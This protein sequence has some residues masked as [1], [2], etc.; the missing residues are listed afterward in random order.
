MILQT[1]RTQFLRTVEL[2]VCLCAI[3]FLSTSVFAQQQPAGEK[4]DVV[5][6]LFYRGDSDQSLRGKEFLEQLQARRPGLEIKAYDVLEDRAQLKRLWQLSKKFGHESGRAPTFYLCNNLLVGFRGAQTTG[7]QIEELLSIRAYIRPGCKHCKAGKAFLDKMMLRR[8]AIKVYYYD[9]IG[10]LNA[11]QEVQNLAAR[12]QVQIPSFPCIQVAGRLVV[13]YQTDETTGKKIEG[14]FVDRSLSTPA[15]Q[16]TI[17]GKATEGEET[18]NNEELSKAASDSSDSGLPQSLFVHLLNNRMIFLFLADIPDAAEDAQ[19]GRPDNTIADTTLP[20]QEDPELPEEV[21]LPDEF[22]LPA[23]AELPSVTSDD[24]IIVTSDSNSVDPENVEIPFFGKLSLSR[25][26]LPAFTFMIGLVDGFNP[27]AMWVLVFLLSVLVNIKERKKILL[28]AGTFVIVSGLAYFTFMAAWFNVF[29]LIGLLRPV[30]IGLGI[31]AIIVGA[32]NV[33]DFF[34]LHKGITLSIP[35][36]AKPGIYRRV[37]QV[38]SAKHMTTA[39]GAAIVLAIV[40]NIVEL[41]CTAGL[42]ALYTEVLTMQE[43]PTWANYSYLALYISAYM[44]DDAILVGIV[45]V[46][47]SHRRLQE[48]EGRWLKLLSGVVILLLGAVMIIRPDLLV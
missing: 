18:G 20:P 13:G 9:V 21:P 38:V 25:L 19:T 12:Y 39:L 28:V 15:P 1:S 10:D 33:K 26:G 48:S 27:C 32:I 23:E 16:Q 47:L 35:E 2:L 4:Q 41:L 37:R 36:S 24:L 45:V 3:C 44:L 34:A 7:K 31:M 40:V 29:Q 17:P 30:Q 43:L 11:R 22:E 14:F 5:I 46:T 42:P 6:E 8:P